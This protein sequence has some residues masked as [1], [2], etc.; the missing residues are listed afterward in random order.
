M[1]CLCEG[2]EAMATCISFCCRI[3][4]FELRAVCVFVYEFVLCFLNQCLFF[5]MCLCFWQIIFVAQICVLG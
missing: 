5:G 3:L 1:L 4:E 2:E